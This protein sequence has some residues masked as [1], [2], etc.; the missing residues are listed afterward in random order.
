MAEYW[1]LY[2]I[3][4]FPILFLLYDYPAVIT[5]FFFF[6]NLMPYI[7]IELMPYNFIELNCQ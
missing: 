3:L 6:Q 5:L 1:L 2:V 4:Q 7:F